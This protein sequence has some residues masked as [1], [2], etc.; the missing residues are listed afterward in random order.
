MASSPVQSDM[1]KVEDVF[2]SVSSPAGAAC[3]TPS[4]YNAMV[5]SHVAVRAKG[6]AE[7]KLQIYLVPVR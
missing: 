2:Q 5:L 3:S 1:E 6:V 4:M 7:I